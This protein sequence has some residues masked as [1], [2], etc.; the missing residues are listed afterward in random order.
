MTA[1]HPGP[2]R[3]PIH[4]FALQAAALILLAFA[5]LPQPK[6][7]YPRLF[8]AQV[9][10][11]SWALGPLGAS[12]ALHLA[13]PESRRDGSDTEMRGFDRRRIEPRWTARFKIF[14]RGYWPLVAVVALVLA[15][16][17]P[18]TRRL[19]AAL[20]GALLVNAFTLAQMSALAVTLFGST[21]AAA[22][23]AEG[24]S[25]ARSVAEHLFNSELPRLGA[26]LVAWALV[27]APGRRLDARPARVWLGE[28]WTTRRPGA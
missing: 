11:L 16:P 2:R 1:T 24:W 15:T 5:W 13:L 25:R 28:R 23:A 18:W 21:E 27:A 9:N 8:H 6:A 3:K 22:A 12:R 7:L 4:V 20:A 26:I 10:G 17:L 14:G 19:A